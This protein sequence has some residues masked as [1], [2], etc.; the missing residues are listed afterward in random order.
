MLWFQNFQMFVLLFLY[1]HQI[2]F[3][4]W[5]QIFLLF[6][7]QKFLFKLLNQP[8]KILMFRDNLALTLFQH[9]LL[10]LS[11]LLLHFLI[12]N[13]LKNPKP[14]KLLSLSQSS[15]MKRFLKFFLTYFLKES[16]SIQIIL[17]K[18]VNSMSSSCWTSIQLK[19]LI[20]LIKTILRGLLF[21]MSNSQSNDHCWL[22]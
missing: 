16:T 13:M 7:L 8:L 3:K 9:Y 17:W 20:T 5:V 6:N 12:V 1:K 22:E 19:L 10:L 11:L 4:F 21:Q 18:P 15:I 2:P 14:Y